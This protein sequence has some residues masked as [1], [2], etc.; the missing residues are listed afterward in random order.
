MIKPPVIIGPP[1]DSDLPITNTTCGPLSFYLDP[2][3]G[4]SVTCEIVPAKNKPQATYP[5]YTNATILGYPLTGNYFEPVI[6]VYPVSDYAALLPDLIS[7]RVAELQNLVAGGAPTGT[8]YPFLP[9][10]N[11]VQV[12]HSNFGLLSFMNGSGIRFLTQYAQYSAPINN[13]EL[14][15]TFQGLTED[16]S[17]WVSITFPIN[18]PILPANASTP[19]NGWTLEQLNANYDV[20]KTDIISQLEAQSSDSFIPSMV[21]LDTLVKSI[22]VAP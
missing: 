9:I 11:A 15:Y 18:H 12:F 5:Q 16:G 20:Y 19:P 22:Q 2:T 13:N 1:V 3:L 21:A 10:F 17:Y 14:F 8:S 4:S 6:E 7:S